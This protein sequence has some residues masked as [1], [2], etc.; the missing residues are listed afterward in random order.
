M[1]IFQFK[2]Q[3]YNNITNKTIKNFIYLKVLTIFES[4]IITLNIF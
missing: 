3:L 2:M 4:V 1:G